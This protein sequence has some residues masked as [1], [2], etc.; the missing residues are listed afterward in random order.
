M[1]IIYSTEKQISPEAVQ[2][3]LDQT[4]WAKSRQLDD[5][6]NMLD[7]SVVVGA[8]SD[9]TLVGFARAFTD[10]QYRAFIEDVVVDEAWRKQGIG[11]GLMQALVQAT[12]HFEEVS[13]FCEDHLLDFYTSLGF[14][15]APHNAMHIWRG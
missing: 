1:P 15:P 13:L 11:R 6:Q 8:W 12:A 5:L 14:E 3:L 4:E 2:K 10:G 7:H 9:E